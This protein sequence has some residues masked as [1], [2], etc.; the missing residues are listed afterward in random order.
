MTYETM[1]DRERRMSRTAVCPLCQAP[2]SKLDDV[3]IV[4]M[5]YGKRTLP[6][7]LHSACLLNSVCVASQL[8]EEVE[9]AKSI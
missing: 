3:Q 8:G 9:N 7:Y 2:I 1:T 6:F 4:K 5:K